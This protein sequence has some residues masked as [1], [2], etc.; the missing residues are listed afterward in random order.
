M[1]VPYMTDRGTFIRSGHEYTFNNIM[2][3]EP[4]VYTKKNND[5]EIT[6]QFNVKRGTG[7]GFN[8]RFIPSTGLFQ[9]SRGTTNAPAYAVFKEL[10]MDDEQIKKQWG[11]E[12]F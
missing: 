12:L 1:K 8:M 11:P 10:G 7:A 6:A 9:F 3:L 2:R 5:D 4:G